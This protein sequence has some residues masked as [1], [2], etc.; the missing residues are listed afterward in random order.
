MEK[1]LDSD[2][3][4]IYYG[5]TTFE[6]IAKKYGTKT[7]NV[8]LAYW[9]RGWKINN[10][11]IVIHNNLTN[12]QL[13]TYSVSECARQLNVS[14]QTVYDVINGKHIKLLDKMQVELE[15]IDG[16]TK[17]VSKN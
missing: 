15:V 2:L 16:K 6:S 8:K 11:I 9:R 14:R 7:A 10:I 3:A 5:K 12:T 13:Y 1:Y 4:D 17:S